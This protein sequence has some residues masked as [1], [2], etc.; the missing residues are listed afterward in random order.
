M[1]T[2]DKVLAIPGSFMTISDK[3]LPGAYLNRAQ[4]SGH[5]SRTK[6]SDT[7]AL[8]RHSKFFYADGS[9]VLQ[10]GR[11]LFRLHKT[12]LS[13]QSSFLRELFADVYRPAEEFE[14]ASGVM[15][16]LYVLSVEGLRVFDFE[17]LLEVAEDPFPVFRADSHESDFLGAVA[18]ASHVLGFDNV[19]AW[20]A[21]ELHSIWPSDLD[22]ISGERQG[23][24]K[25][26]A[27]ALQIA[28]DAN[29]PQIRKG[30]LYELL[31]TENFGQDDE[32]PMLPVATY[33]ALTRARQLCAT[34]WMDLL[35]KPPPRSKECQE[36]ERERPGGRSRCATRR[37]G[38][39]YPMWFAIV[40]KEKLRDHWLDPV[41]GFDALEELEIPNENNNGI[42][43]ACSASWKELWADKGS[44]FWDKLDEVLGTTPTP[45]PDG[46]KD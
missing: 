8:E 9:V 27:A 40:E 33:N 38:C 41:A 5:S 36:S 16:P 45:A 37:T 30:A 26:A 42:C 7:R 20:A 19:H 21:D 44:E 17:R 4:V 23:Y 32:N 43:V 2:G 12:L 39:S 18:R 15:L 34:F 29:V 10:V 24:T 1:T 11:T 22:S 6:L 3:E 14:A 46:T 31:R 28:K 35:L 25:D 13:V